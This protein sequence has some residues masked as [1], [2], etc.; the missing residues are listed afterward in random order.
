MK[1]FL[2]YSIVS[3]LV[4]PFIFSPVMSDKTASHNFSKNKAIVSIVQSSNS[5]LPSPIPLDQVP[6]KGEIEDMVRL[7]VG[8]QGG[9]NAFV[10]G[11]SLVVIKPNIVELESS[12]TGII[13]D[14]KVVRAIAK[15]VFEVN[16]TAHIIIGEA[17]GGW[18]LSDTFRCLPGT[19]IGDGFTVAG[20]RDMLL[21]SF[22]LDKKIDI[23]DLNLDYAEEVIVDTPYYAQ[24]SYFI[25]KTL[26]DA[27]CIINAPVMKI[28]FV[29]ITAS[30]KNN[31]GIL[32]GLIYGW[33]KAA[34]YPYPSNTGLKHSRDI[35][36]EE[37]VDIA[38]IV[39]KKIKLTVVD[40]IMCREMTKGSSGLPKRRNMVVAGKDM[41]ALDAVCSQLMGLNPDDIEHVTLAGIKGLGISNIDSIQIFGDSVSSA[42]TEFIKDSAGNGIFG[43]SNRVW[44]F[45]SPFFNTDIDYD[46]L[47]GEVSFWPNPEQ[48]IWG[49]PLYFFD[50]YI[51]CSVV[52][53]D[54]NL[55]IYAH[56]Y[57]YSPR[58]GSA[59]LWIGSDEDIKAIL[60]GTEVYRYNGTRTHNL[61]N[62]IISVS[63]LQGR[64]RL[65]VKLVQR[66]GT[67][68]FCLNICEPDA[69]PEYHGNRVFGLKFYPDSS[70]TCV[71]E[72]SMPVPLYVYV[73]PNPSV[74]G[75]FFH[76]YN[77][78]Q[79]VLELVIY[80]LGGRKLEER[81]WTNSPQV[82]YWRW[83]PKNNLP[84]GAYFYTVRIGGK[85]AR[86]EKGKIILLQ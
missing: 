42:R 32:P 21:D 68:D 24:P 51:N 55:T 79:D 61:P 63:I 40:A 45:S 56:T 27:D 60:N 77:N 19:A 13:T 74:R 29:G 64:N 41:V 57:F 48:G 86:E 16:P 75:P 62:E 12:G 69:R 82:I 38:S 7:S 85:N 66:Q 26:L 30:L 39:N 84:A 35:K 54:S 67:F 37:I 72:K 28:H 20:Y 31:I 1:K 11:C 4:F 3:F 53:P 25:P 10:N 47:G 81:K 22:F 34:G 5:S 43:Q 18:C 59:E 46:N 80:D 52:T 6:T 73:S 33:P 78:Q 49:R 8:L 23:L 70:L 36:D 14:A 2:F 76:I 17:S 71:V 58:P 50:D 44:I 9:M 15:L 83:S 65:L